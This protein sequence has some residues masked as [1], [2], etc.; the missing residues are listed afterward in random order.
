MDEWDEAFERLLRK[1]AGVPAPDGPTPRY[2]GS[3]PPAAVQHA[4]Y[5][6]E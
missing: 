6:G 3:G 5:R 1:L 2:L 4:V